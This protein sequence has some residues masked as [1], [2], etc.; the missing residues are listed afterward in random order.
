[1]QL[2]MMKIMVTAGLVLGLSCLAEKTGPRWAGVIAG[3]PLGT[4]IVLGFYGVEFGTSFA[5]EAALAA[6]PGLVAS[7]ALTAGYLAGMQWSRPTVLGLLPPLALASA[8]YCLVALGLQL[9]PWTFFTA[10]IFTVAGTYGFVRAFRHIQDS[11]VLA[12]RPL[13]PF[14]IFLRAAGASALVLAITGLAAVLPARL[15]GI[16][17]PFPTTLLPTMVIVHLS[18]G[19]DPVR[20]MI[21][22]FPTGLGALVFYLTVVHALFVPL[23]VGPAT[24]AGFAAAT[25][26]LW[27][28]QRWSRG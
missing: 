28:F 25:G 23:G 27:M 7:Q 12:A 15:S 21:R 16:L 2:W 5:S 8:A 20:T 26:Y 11:G 10:L 24:V 4:A 6:L 1:M 22:F 13:T 9:V 18:Y 14:A 3:Y 19:P 17:A